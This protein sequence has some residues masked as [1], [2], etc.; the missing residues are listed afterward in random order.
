MANEIFHLFVDKLI[1]WPNIAFNNIF[2]QC[3]IPTLNPKIAGCVFIE[4][5]LHNTNYKL[6]VINS[7]VIEIS[8]NII[9]KSY[10]FL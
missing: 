9:M 8:N 5:S 6:L 3:L 10:C 1:I 4:Y 7:E 2:N